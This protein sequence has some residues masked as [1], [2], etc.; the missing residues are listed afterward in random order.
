VQEACKRFAETEQT[1]E[2][3]YAKRSLVDQVKQHIAD[4][5]IDPSM[6]VEGIAETCGVGVSPH[7]AVKDI[8]DDSLS[9]YIQLRPD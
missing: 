6:S 9:D 4:N 5:L 7:E 2:H 1:P 3:T 8:R